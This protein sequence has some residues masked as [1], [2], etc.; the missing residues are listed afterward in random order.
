MKISL[1]SASSFL[2]FSLTSNNEKPAPVDVQN[3]GDKKILLSWESLSRPHQADFSANKLTRTFTIIGVVIAFV[4]IILGE[5]WLLLVIGSMLF[6]NYVLSKVPPEKISYTI[7]THG[8]SVGGTIYYWAD[9]TDFF[10]K[11]TEGS[12][13]V[14]IGVRGTTL[15]RIYLTYLAK[16]REEIHKIL[17]EHLVY[18]EK[19]PKSTFDRTYEA[20]MGKLDTK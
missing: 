8:V 13:V 17:A 3:L 7:S 11:D 12:N 6:V 18:L 19:E 1:P 16:D 5:F 2:G 15:P 4:L 9:L 14:I 10:F 20:L